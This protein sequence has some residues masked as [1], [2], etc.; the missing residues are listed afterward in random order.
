MTHCTDRVG[1]KDERHTGG[2]RQGWA[3]DDRCSEIGLLGPLNLQL[4]H[5]EC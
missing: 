4:D 5:R 3:Y 1:F 2:S